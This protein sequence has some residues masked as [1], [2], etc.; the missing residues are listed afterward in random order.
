MSE[1]DPF[2]RESCSEW[3]FRRWPVG[4]EFGVG[5][6]VGEPLAPSDLVTYAER[7]SIDNVTLLTSPSATAERSQNKV[8]FLAKL[9]YA[10]GGTSDIFGHW[11]YNALANPVFVTFRGLSPTAVSSAVGAARMVD[12]FTDPLF[13]WLSDNA[14]TKHGRRRPFILLGSLLAG[15]ALPCLF[16]APKSFSHEHVLWFMVISATLNAAFLSAGTMAHQSLGSELTPSYHERTSIMAWKA[17][18]QKLAGIITASGF[19]FATL[20]MFDDSATG[21]PDIARGATWLA[22]ICGAI[23]IASGFMN[24]FFV[25]EPYYEKAKLQKKVPFFRTFAG[26]FRCKPYLVLLGVAFAYAI[27]TGFVGSLGYY[28]TTYYVCPHDLH[29]AARITLYSGIAYALLGIAGVPVAVSFSRVFGKKWALTYTLMTGLLAFGS[30]WWMFTPTYPWLSVLCAGFNGFSATGLWVVLP[31]MCA[32]VVDY[33]EIRSGKRLEGAFASSFAWVLKVGMSAAM[34]IV[35]P[36][37]DYV[38]GFD[39]RLANQSPETIW[40]IRALFTA[41]PV[42][43]LV[44]ALGLAQLFPLTEAK[45]ATVRLELEARRGVV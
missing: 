20:P 30:T 38:T 44:A 39:P 15:L 10:M 17:S 43:A 24:F 11:L 9:S 14:R 22:T 37:L 12:A 34:F 35:G 45:M 6:L 36:L 3:S 4:V 40:W 31:S 16:L 7:D 28:A 29:A 13:G 41:I 26:T 25:R 2:Y 32:D 1:F 21:K 18:L 33:D 42:V 23:M 19:W 8:P 27:P 5:V